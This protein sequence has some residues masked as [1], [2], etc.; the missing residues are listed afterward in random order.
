MAIENGY[1]ERSISEAAYEYQMRIE[2]G[3]YQV[4]GLNEREEE[5]S[6]PPELYEHDQEEEPRQIERL[7]AIIETRDS[8]K[9][10]AALA[11]LQN[12]AKEKQ[13]SMPAILEAANANATEGEIMQALRE[14]FGD[15]Q[16][17]G[18]F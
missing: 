2:T 16:D 18:V 15:H 9:T 4:L 6:L 10:N 5:S 7:Q 14:V 1:I 3:E 12:A 11:K 13:N 8:A 17:P